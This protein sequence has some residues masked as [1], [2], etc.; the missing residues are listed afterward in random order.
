MLREDEYFQSLTEEEIWQRYCGFL[1]LSLDE[2]MKIQED[3]LMEEIDLVADSVLGKKIMGGN[4]PAN[5]E[6]FRKVVPLTTYED[7][8][9]YINNC[10]DDALSIKPY[11]W[12]HTSGRGGDFKW[13]PYTRSAFETITRHTIAAGLLASA[14]TK[15][16]VNLAPGLRVLLNVASRPYITGSLFYYLS[17]YFSFKAIPPLEQAE[18]MEFQE[19]VEKGFEIALRDRVDCI[20]SI[21]SVLAKI[22]EKSAQ[23]TQ[24]IKFSPFMLRP[25]VL[26]LLARAWL[27]SKMQ[28]R[29]ILPK[30]LWSSKAIITSGTDTAIYRDE[31]AYYWG[32]APYE[33]YSSTEMVMGAI[34]SWDKKKGMYFLP[35]VAFWEFIPEDERIKKREDNTYQPSTVLLNETKPGNRYELVL[36]HFHGMPFLRYCIGDLIEIT[37]MSD[38]ETGINLPQM[39]FQ[40]RVDGVIHLASLTELDEKTIWQAIT[41][42]G[43]KYEDWSA[44][45]EYAQNHTF[46]HLYLE[47]KGDNTAEQMELMVDEQLKLIDKDYRDLNSLLDLR[48]VKVTLLSQ[49]TFQRYYEEKREQG[50]DLSHLKPPHI[51]QSDEV[52][53]ELLRLSQSSLS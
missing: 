45:K 26:S 41:N 33:A 20:F 44:C 18:E 43:L 51:A 30:D 28:R 13:V 35:N 12:A 6:E 19:R 50:A 39:V 16:Q 53:Q 15:G 27:R 24:K 47:I 36:T 22:G 7:Y 9:P 21:S 32:T 34:Q 48:P 29:G 42:T 31:I 25:Q 14:E 3:L 17:E 49:G 40:T 52:I 46:L 1:D 11:F 8:V 23:E 5:M 4:R 10:Q 38:I 2:F 37:T